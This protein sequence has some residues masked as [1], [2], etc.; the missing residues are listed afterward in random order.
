MAANALALIERHRQ[1]GCPGKLRVVSFENDLD[2]LRTALAHRSSWDFVERNAEAL[3]ALLAHRFWS[4]ENR[5]WTLLEGDFR[6]RVGEAP[7]ADLL[8]WD[9]Y[10][11]KTC[12]GLWDVATFDLVRRGAVKERALLLTYSAATPVRLGLVLAGFYV[13]RGPR[14]PVKGETTQAATRLED[15]ADPLGPEWIEKLRR[16]AKASPYGEEWE[17]EP[18]LERILASPQFR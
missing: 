18:L 4:A 1:L 9:F 13:G 10:D 3:E 5:E 14:T 8:F 6:A 16:S 11:P 12:P 15:L 7:P 2:G 17:I